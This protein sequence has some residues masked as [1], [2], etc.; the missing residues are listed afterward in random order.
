VKSQDKP[1]IETCRTGVNFE[2]GQ[3]KAKVKT[4]LLGHKVEIG[5]KVRDLA[6]PNLA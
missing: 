5:V 1:K 3:L 6:T 2:K 4:T